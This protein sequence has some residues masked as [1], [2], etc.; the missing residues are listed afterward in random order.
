MAQFW[1][2]KSFRHLSKIWNNKLKQ[3]DFL[4]AEI[5]LGSERALKQRATNCYNQASELERETRFEYYSFLGY[6]A[7]N[8]DFISNLDRI[9][10]IMHADGATIKEIVKELDKL[11]MPRERKTVGR[12]IRRWQMS[13]GIRSWSLK[14]MYLRK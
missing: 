4:D 7:Q 2:T 10:M 3:S 11:N 13:W 12:I 6:L 14:Q 1:R 8:T 5:E 9:I